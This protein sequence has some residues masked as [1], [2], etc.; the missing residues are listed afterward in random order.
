LIGARTRVVWVQGDGTDP[1]ASGTNLLLMGLDTD[2]RQGERVVLGE[3]ASYIKPLF[4][5]KGERILYT[6]R[7]TPPHDLDTYIVNWDGSGKK[8][9]GDGAALAVWQDPASGKNWVYV[10][11][12]N[13][14]ETPGDF[15]TV[16][17]FP[18]DEPAAR[19]LVWN[20]TPV[21]G[22]TFQVSTDG[23]TAGGLFPWPKAGVA[24]LP[25]G[26]LRTLGEGCWT[27]YRDAGS[28]LF[29]YFDGAHRN[30]TIVDRAADRRWMVALNGAPGFDNPEVYHPR[31]TN[32]PRFLAISG[33][34]NQGGANQVRTGGRQA[35]IHLG[36]F[37]PDYSR[38]EAW[39]RVT[40]N[41]GGD[42]YPDV[43]I[44]RE[45]SP[46]AIP[47]SRSLVT[48]DEA[49]TAPGTIVV[50]ARLAHVTP[51]PPPRSIAPYRHA[52]GVNRYDVVKVVEG[53]FAA[54]RIYVAQWAIRD[55]RVLAEASGRSVGTVSRLVLERYD[56]HPELEGERLLSDQ[57][58]GDE[59]LYY[60][61]TH[62]P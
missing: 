14:A 33:P 60:D 59:P 53:Q 6:S 3:R 23:R 38:I 61:V 58:S 50:D 15:K 56:A 62:R 9:L 20:Q 5:G 16:S 27:A 22:D 17:R 35:E 8:R 43:W 40:N 21:S 44:D 12:D 39:A 55:A 47:I 2:D 1:T 28:G 24:S 19:E 37:S 11:E 29:W 34:Y 41:D 4:I 7:G 52:L 42:S 57:S 26:E 30:V 31:W 25:N 13:S 46:H 10:G 45:N 49:E 18:V 36:R 48:N 51:I 54:G 32:H